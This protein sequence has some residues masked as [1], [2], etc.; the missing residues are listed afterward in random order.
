MNVAKLES[1]RPRFTKKYISELDP[2]EI[3]VFG[4]NAAGVHG[5]YAARDA[6][7][8][9]AIYGKASGI[10]G[11]AYA[12]PTKDRS[13]KRPLSRDE[14]RR[15]VEEF[16]VFAAM[17]PQL[18]FLVTPIGC[19]AAGYSFKQIAPMFAD[20]IDLDNVCL[21]KEFFEVLVECNYC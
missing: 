16:V 17:N 4:S 11:N 20:A 7:K 8:F 6:L 2:N 13:I 15:Y 18:K 1:F 5:R 19:G 21:P 12:I 3:F 14:V 9:G 10:Q